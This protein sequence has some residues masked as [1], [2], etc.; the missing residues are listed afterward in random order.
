MLRF[1]KAIGRKDKEGAKKKQLEWE[2]KNDH[3][4]KNLLDL[5]QEKIINL[6]AFVMIVKTVKTSKKR[7]INDQN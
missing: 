7:Q 3:T 6:K 5:I 2:Q 1:L 4:S